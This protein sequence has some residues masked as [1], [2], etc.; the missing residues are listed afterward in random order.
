MTTVKETDHDEEKEMRKHVRH[1]GFRRIPKR[2]SATDKIEW[3]S[4]RITGHIRFTGFQRNESK[5]KIP[6]PVDNKKNNNKNKK[7]DHDD[8]VDSEKH[9]NVISISQIRELFMSPGAAR[10]S[11][12][13]DLRS[14][15][16][17]EDSKSQLSLSVNDS[18]ANKTFQE[19]YE[20][21]DFLGE[22]G[23]A[24]V[25]RC[26]HV[27]RGHTYAVKEIENEGY[28][29][30]DGNSFK[31]EIN[32]MKR[33]REIP[34][35]VRLLDVFYAYDR[36][37][38]I[39]EE[40]TGGDLLDKIAEK[41]F[42]P[43]AECR[44]LA[45]RLF[46]AIFYCHKKRIVHRD[47]KPE[48]IL[49]ESKYDD[50]KIKLADFGCAKEIL[51]DTLLVTMCGT[52]QYVAPEIYMQRSGYDEKCD[53][54]SAAVVVYLLLAGYVPFD[55]SEPME[56]H[57]IVCAGEYEF[58]PKYW[59]EVSEAPK[60]LIRDLLKVDPVERASIVE[61]LDTGWLKRLDREKALQRRHSESSL[62]KSNADQSMRSFGNKSPNGSMRNFGNESLSGGGSLDLN[63]IE[64]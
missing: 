16:K 60:Q 39:M 20:K 11:L 8:K 33:L 5:R 10:P 40:M 13:G 7:N 38:L 44:K 52:P 2:N 3:K 49:L 19:C 37:F 56:V 41:E 26:R 21:Q 1:M 45:R 31:E 64:E 59:S 25:H 24:V 23:F 50:T 17:R 15:F 18:A 30:T 63:M 29:D 57:K 54:W 22:G 34:Y 62:L 46:E 58:H 6:V 51:E 28:E 32:T 47:I 14:F 4:Q 9:D 48:N 55:S 43:E 35:I 36:T 42:Y 53:L 61:I 12:K 27:E